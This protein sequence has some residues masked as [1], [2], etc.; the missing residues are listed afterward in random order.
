[1]SFDHTKEVEVFDAVNKESLV[2]S[3][4]DNLAKSKQNLLANKMITKELSVVYKNEIYNLHFKGSG[5]Y[6]APGWYEQHRKTQVRIVATLK[7]CPF[8]V[9]VDIRDCTISVTPRLPYW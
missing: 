9:I 1:M 5:K 2:N 6:S 8:E 3:V 4:G 7:E